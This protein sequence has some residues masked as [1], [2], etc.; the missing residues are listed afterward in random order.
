MGYVT[1][2]ERVRRIEAR[3]EKSLARYNEMKS[4]RDA[5]KSPAVRARLTKALDELGPEIGRTKAYL[6]ELKLEPPDETQVDRNRKARLLE[7]EDALIRA[8]DRLAERERSGQVDG[9]KAAR[10]DVRSLRNE[11]A[12]Y[13][14][15]SDALKWRKEALLKRIKSV[16]SQKERAEATIAWADEEVADLQRRLAEL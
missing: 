10:R 15:E 16:Q 4:K 9:L 12:K 1:N 2:A 7:V 11:A 6:F 14:P 8:E 5:S 13:R 3:V